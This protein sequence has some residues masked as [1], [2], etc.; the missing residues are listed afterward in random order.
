[1]GWHAL[2]VPT[3]ARTGLFV[4]RQLCWRASRAPLGLVY[5]RHEDREVA[6]AR[7]VLGPVPTAR[8]VTVIATYHRP[9]GLLAAVRSAL[10]QTVRDQ[11]VVV[12]DD[13]GGL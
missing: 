1:R 13:G 6:L 11:L 4:G 2:P 5:R 12:V 7:A 8:V 9:E 3:A 10:A